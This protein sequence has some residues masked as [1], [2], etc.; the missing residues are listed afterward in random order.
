MTRIDIPKA[1][2]NTFG[3]THIIQTRPFLAHHDAALLR[4]NSLYT[5][6]GVLITDSTYCSGVNVQGSF[7]LQIHAPQIIAIETERDQCERGE[8]FHDCFWIGYFHDHFGHFLTSTLA[9]LWALDAHGLR[10]QWYIA[11]TYTQSR[12]H[13]GFILP[14]LNSLGID[15]SRIVAPPE[16]TLIRGVRIAEPAFVENAH[17]YREWGRFMQAIGQSFLNRH[18]RH[19]AS[20]PVFLARSKASATTRRYDGEHE[21]SVLLASLG[22]EI[23]HPQ[24]LPFAEQLDL[25]AS[26]SIFVGFSGSAFMNAA[27]FQGKTVIILNHD[28]YIFGTQRMID[29]IG[30]HHAVYL[31]V[32]AFLSVTDS[33][34]HHYLIREPA[35]LAVEIVQACRRAV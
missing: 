7:E 27:F 3:R 24:E 32:S 16:N 6:A 2:P 19:S 31:D 5:P 17:C 15:H 18:Q 8:V 25:W 10:A 9:R 21:L 23:V 30:G 28:G 12:D 22:I 4:H 13:D 1:C 11:P 33:E 14:I 34:H 35:R 26:H 29:T 20:R